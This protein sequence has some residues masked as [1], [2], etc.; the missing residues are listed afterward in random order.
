M[1]GVERL[2]VLFRPILA[3]AFGSGNHDTRRQV[4]AQR[5]PME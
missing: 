1:A 4:A 2:G 5:A 3:K